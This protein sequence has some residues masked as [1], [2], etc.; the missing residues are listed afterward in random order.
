MS[1]LG[2]E[3]YITN[4][5]TKIENLS[6]V[7]D[8]RC[9]W[10]LK[11]WS[12]GFYCL[13]RF[14][15]LRH[16]TW[17]GLRMEYQLSDL[18]GFFESNAHHLRSLEL[19][20]SQEVHV[21]EEIFE[22]DLLARQDRGVRIRKYEQLLLDKGLSQFGWLLIFAMTAWYT[23][24]SKSV[25]YPSL[26]ALSL[27]N[28]SFYGK[29]ETLTQ[30]IDFSMLH[31]LKLHHCQGIAALF[32]MVPHG[33]RLKVLHLT[34]S[35]HPGRTT[36]REDLLAFI[37]F[38]DQ[39]TALEELCLQLYTRVET[40]YFWERF[41]RHCASLR[42]FVYHERAKMSSA[43]DINTI[44]RANNGRLNLRAGIVDIDPFS[45]RKNYTHQNPDYP[46]PPDLF[47]QLL[48]ESNLDL[49]AINMNPEML[50]SV[51]RCQHDGGRLC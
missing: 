51:V 11:E 42:R 1:V 2:P 41:M 47:S 38:L 27:S 21:R 14:K 46:R 36:H 10:G 31:T 45:G 3:G 32:P 18:C 4:Y 39:C 44:D 37:G 34:L 6:L 25:V 24:P 50:V 12:G 16:L 29:S 30:I 33:L 17:K 43:D 19:E 13:E 35:L 23:G 28:I 49:F 7:V 8:G 26:R 15:N 22:R 20:L 5:Q 40:H 9:D 48:D